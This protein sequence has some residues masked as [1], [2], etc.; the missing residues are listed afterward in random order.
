MLPTVDPD[1][2]LW[3]NIGF[4][5][6]DQQMRSVVSVIVQVATMVISVLITLQMENLVSQV[7][8]TGC[9]CP[10]EPIEPEDAYAEQMM[11]NL[12]EIVK[13]KK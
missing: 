5:V 8:P 13:A 4:S 2:I 7:D 12:I 11:M 9:D 10:T 3:N 1:Q 6:T